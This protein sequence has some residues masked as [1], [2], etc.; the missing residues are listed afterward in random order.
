MAGPVMSLNNSPAA[1]PFLDRLKLSEGYKLRLIIGLGY[2]DEAP[3]AR[4][5]DLS[6]IKFVD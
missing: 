3:A 6:K 2:P 4:P 5:R 1:K